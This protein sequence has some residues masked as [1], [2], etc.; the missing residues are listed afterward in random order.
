[1]KIK[2][3][4]E[5]MTTFDF[6]ELVRDVGVPEDMQEFLQHLA[7]ANQAYSVRNWEQAESYY[8]AALVSLG[9]I[10]EDPDNQII[11]VFKPF[12]LVPL[13]RNMQMQGKKREALSFYAN[14]LSLA[15]DPEMITNNKE[16]IDSFLEGLSDEAPYFLPF[17]NALFGE[18]LDFMVTSTF[19]SL[20]NLLRGMDE[21][22]FEQ[23]DEVIQEGIEFTN[24]IGQIYWSSSLHLLRAQILAECDHREAAL[25]E[26][27]LALAM[28][29]RQDDDLGYSLSFFLNTVAE[30][31]RDSDR[32]DGALT[33]A[34]EVIDDS[35]IGKFV[36]CRAYLS[37]AYSLEGL[38][39]LDEAKEFADKIHSLAKET[40]DDSIALDAHVVSVP[41]LIKQGKIEDAMV[42][43]VQA[44]IISRR[45]QQTVPE[46]IMRQFARIRLAQAYISLGLP[47]SR[48]ATINDTL[49]AASLQLAVRY[50]NSARR[51]LTRAQAAINDKVLRGGGFPPLRKIETLRAKAD[52]LASVINSGR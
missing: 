10:Q 9:R 43:A 48:P 15:S 35:S 1:M 13:A 7:L 11:H 39:K 47:S 31:Q 23:I 12:V 25:K 51:W 14:V 24:K 19:I 40:E 41:I 6:N 28:R 45:E 42:A 44:W 3:L 36:K 30:F 38:G 49:P 21:I 34:Q 26:G 50:I 22:P 29:R 37:I 33:T 5:M 46:F 17:M 52:Y 27:E 2:E 4:Q 20:V 32:F 18:G 8:S 16:I